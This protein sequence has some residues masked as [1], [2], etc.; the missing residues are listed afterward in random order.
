[1][2]DKML[3]FNIRIGK[4]WSNHDSMIQLS[5]TISVGTEV[6]ALLFLFLKVTSSHM[7]CYILPDTDHDTSFTRI[8]KIWVKLFRKALI[9]FFLLLLKTFG[10]V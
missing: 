2:S 1:M 8:Y 7:N 10:W 3:R 6:W 9:I 4:Q 5:I